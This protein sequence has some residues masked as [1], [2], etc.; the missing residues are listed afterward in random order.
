MTNHDDNLCSFP[1]T[2]VR[3][4]VVSLISRTISRVDPTKAV[5]TGGG[6]RKAGNR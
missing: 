2:S 4:K 5:P 6:R 3:L 1:D